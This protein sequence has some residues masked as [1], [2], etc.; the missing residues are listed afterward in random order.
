MAQVRKLQHLENAVSAADPLNSESRNTI[1]FSRGKTDS[2]VQC[3]P[4]LNKLK[5]TLLSET[6]G[7]SVLYLFF[8]NIFLH[9]FVILSSTSDFNVLPLFLIF[10]AFSSNSNRKW[11]TTKFDNH[12]PVPLWCGRRH[13]ISSGAQP[14]SRGC[15]R[16]FYTFLCNNLSFL[17]VGLANRWV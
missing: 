9:G 16:V 7:Y 13:N 10:V 8:T 3:W 11:L 1:L 17:F 2:K 4:W 5:M 15:F 6:L 12:E 14:A